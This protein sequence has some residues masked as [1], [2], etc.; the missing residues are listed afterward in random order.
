MSA[1][2]SRTTRI[3]SSFEEYKRSLYSSE[4]D[5]IR[6]F[7]LSSI[8]SIA[9][10]MRLPTLTTMLPTESFKR[11]ETSSNTLSTRVFTES[12]TL[13]MRA[14]MES[15]SDSYCIL[16]ASASAFKRAE[17]SSESSSLRLSGLSSFFFAAF[18]EDTTE[19]N[20][21]LTKLIISFCAF[22]RVSSWNS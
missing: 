22:L 7:A 13:S 19:S 6:L 2:E 16:I 17:S 21:V 8:V 14:L 18:S 11:L 9:P 3:T 10:S 5:S 20:F 4:I 12:I 1:N 15:S